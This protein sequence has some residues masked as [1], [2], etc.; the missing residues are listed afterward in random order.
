MKSSFRG[1]APLALLLA[2]APPAAR[3]I[4]P[5]PNAIVF[6]RANATPA[7]MTLSGDK[8]T[9]SGTGGFSV[10]DATAKRAVNLAPGTVLEGTAYDASGDDVRIHAEFLPRRD[11]ILVRGEVENLRGGERGLIVDYRIPALGAGATFS[12]GLEQSVP[13]PASGEVEGNAFPLAAL[14]GSSAG[15]AL[16]IPPTEPRDFGLVASGSG[17][18][19]RFYLGLSPKPRRFPNRASFVFI[20]YGTD[21][22]WGFRSALSRYYGFFPDNYTPLLKHEGLFMFQMADRVPAN[23]DQYGWDLVENQFPKTVL[24]KA[25]ARDQAN[26]ITT[27]PYTIVGQREVKFLPELP[28]DYAAAM[29]IFAQWT[30]AQMAGHELTKENVTDDGDINLAAEVESSACQN[31]AGEYVVVIRDTLW[32]KKSVTFKTNP[33]PDL[34]SDL[35][36]KTVGGDQL[37]VDD[38][39]LKE[40]PEF[41]GV[42]V[43]SLGANWPALFNYRPD[44]YVY[45]RYPLTIDPSGRVALQ[46]TTSHYEFLETLRAKLRQSGRLIM[47][48]GIYTYKSRGVSKAKGLELQKFDTTA[49]E[50]IRG[51]GPPEHY[52]PGTKLGRFFYC[53]LLDAATCEFG[54]KA[55]V[56]NCQDNRAMMGRKAY[57]FINYSWHDGDK[58]KEFVNK[59]LAYGIYASTTTDYANTITYEDKPEYRRDKPV[60]DWYVP[61][62]RTLA[63]AGWE[64]V[65]HATIAG[66]QVFGERFGAGD[67]VYFT[68]YND[69]D[70][71]QAGTLKVDLA[72][73][74]Y[75][76]DN[77]TFAEIA[78]NAAP[79]RS[80][81]EIL[82]V[83]VAPKRTCILRLTRAVR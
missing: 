26:G 48:N 69:S 64:P 65:R 34:F 23:V 61:L 78:Q 83:T 3:A 51:G 11:Y 41:G 71:P 15:V 24:D 47:G 42:F 1:F 82:T 52:R 68:L 77:A 39:W 74:G 46:N 70:A 18:S 43:D 10:Y 81:P 19:I 12:N 6:G 37:G 58:I 54:T 49:N 55:S 30:P 36:R 14:S 63:A 67:T 31:A 56:D 8:L 35:A 32:G 62:V 50:Y 27:F 45:A 4:D 33:N 72:A 5:P 40:H 66:E 76:P 44:H 53:A 75:S 73:L 79:A 9:L 16:A 7:A 59:C 2:L 60:L 29:K 21:P 20:I 25:V 57:A 22:Q 28:K 17:L 13:L 38:R 80:S